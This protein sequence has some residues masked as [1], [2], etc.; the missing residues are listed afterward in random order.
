MVLSNRF[1]LKDL[2]NL[3]YFLGM[4]ATRTEKRLLLTQTK[5][6]TDLLHRTNMTNAKPVSTPMSATQ[7]LTLTDGSPLTDPTSYRTTI[8]SLQY[9]GLTRPNIAIAVNCFSQYMHRPTTLH[10]KAMKR[11]FH[12]LAGTP[13]KGIFFICLDT[14]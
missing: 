3:S 6:I 12:Y 13:D 4:E 11:V 5:Y 14:I 10:E 8:G 2:G 7:V 1:S 9:L